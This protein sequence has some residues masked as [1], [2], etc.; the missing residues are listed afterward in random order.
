MIR[1]V[2]VIDVNIFYDKQEALVC[3]GMCYTFKA[4]ILLY[5]YI[6]S[7]CSLCIN[8]FMF[9]LRFSFAYSYLFEVCWFCIR[10][11]LSISRMFIYW[12]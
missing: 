9:N 10:I 11:M 1:I 3:I 12:I 6:C 2:H 7:L 4:C 8:V 5:I